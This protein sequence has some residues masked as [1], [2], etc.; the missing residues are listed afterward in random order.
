MEQII[1]Y[2]IIVIIVFN[3]FFERILSYLNINNMKAQLPKEAEDIYDENKYRKSQEYNKESSKF[4]IISSTLGFILI[5]GML[6]FEGFAYV[7]VLAR[8]ISENPIIIALLFFGILAIASDI[9]FTPFDIY[10]TFVIEEK[11]GFNKT[12]T[13]TYIMDKIKG[14][15]LGAIVGG[16]LIA[17]ITWF[18]YSTGIYFWVYTWVALIIFMVLSSMFYASLIIPLFNKLTPL[19]EGEL[20]SAIE[21]YCKKTDF[22]LDDLF[23]MDSSKRSSKG[24]AFFSGFGSHKKIVLFDT[25]IE[26]HTV[27]ELVAVLAHEVGHYKKKHTLQG[28]FLGIIQS[29][30]M[31][32]ILSWFIDSPALAGA[33]S[34]QE[35]SFHIGVL[36]FSLLYTPLSIVLGIMMN[37]NSRKNE[38]EADKYAKETYNESALISAL[39]KLSSDNLSNL[40]PHPAYIFVYYSHPPLL[41]RINALR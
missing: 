10:D 13:K 9:I 3:Y 34:V 4:S 7:D 8:S 5:L 41:E 16:G 24:N 40:T 20:R 14:Y 12:T 6:F 39:K 31:L 35:P 15:L 26:K 29:G 17:L 1:F 28:M 27:E 38:F 30:F 21:S 23:V 11:Y 25:L 18:Y 33:L 2:L 22:K 37:A 32:F 19:P 36:V